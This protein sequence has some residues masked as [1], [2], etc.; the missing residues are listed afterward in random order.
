VG[1][2]I[3]TAEAAAAAGARVPQADLPANDSRMLA[4]QVRVLYRSGWYP[5]LGDMAAALV[6]WLTYFMLTG[7][8]AAFVWAGLI[9]AAQA[10]RLINTI[11]YNRLAQRA[12]DQLRWLRRYVW[13]VGITA[14]AWG[15]ALW[16]LLPAPSLSGVALL[17]LVILGV[18]SAGIAAV[19]ACRPA[20]QAWLLPLLLPVPVALLWHRVPYAPALCLFT[21]AYLGVNLVFALNQNRLLIRALGA[22][23]V[24]EA[25]IEQ[26]RHQMELAAR[27]NRDKSRF[28]AAASHDLRQP[29][30]ALTLFAGALEKR[31]AGTQELP[32]MQNMNEC[33]A[34]LDRSFN[35]ML[36]ISKLD[37]GVVEVTRHSF[38]IRDVFRRLHMHFAGQAE[39]ANLQLRFKPGGKLVTTDPQLLERVLGNLIQNAIKY[40]REGGVVVVAR[41]AGRD[42]SIEVWDTGLGIPEAE[43]PRI[44]DEFYQL[45]NPQHDRSRGL[46]MGLA[47]VKRLVL[48]LGH[49][50]QVTSRPGRGTLFRIRVPRMD[51]QALE[52]MDVGAETVPSPIGNAGTL[53]VID[54]EAKIRESTALL[55]EQWGYQ[56]IVAG[57]GFE[58]CER[59]RE[60]GQGIHAIIS[61]LRLRD[62][63]T[64]L[65]AIDAVQRVLGQALPALLVTG[66]TSEEQIQKVHDSGHMVLFKPV[67]PKELYSALRRL[68]ASSG[69]VTG[70]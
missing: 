12:G 49:T 64:G 19:V 22:K 27:A 31:L 48:L 58:A 33:I 45:D 25:L 3:A 40:T 6:F 32:L 1:Y 52:G 10:G 61:D 7:D 67:R 51:P 69:S 62:G 26:L 4:A 30:H 28:L 70:T 15:S 55:L 8:R 2:R 68:G 24:N 5:S 16:L 44:F 13:A 57:S 23:Y 36:D 17:L 37:A 53:L 59:A 18:A 47:I 50:L 43:L 66:D 46:G 56:A 42:V 39:A 14:A 34:S 38:A 29:M 11:E 63:E 9:H 41:N 54:D 65:H 21:L 60:H 35:A 20:V